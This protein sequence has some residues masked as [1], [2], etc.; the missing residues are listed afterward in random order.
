MN[1]C[2]N[3]VKAILAPVM[4]KPDSVFLDLNRFRSFFLTSSTSLS[5]SLSTILLPLRPAP[6]SPTTL[7]TAFLD[8]VDLVLEVFRIEVGGAAI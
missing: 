5:T 1:A 6:L 8:S 4:R 7:I 3:L 2:L